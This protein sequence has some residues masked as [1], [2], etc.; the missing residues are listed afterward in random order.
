L[1]E[2]YVR[3]H[4]QIRP[5][6]GGGRLSIIVEDSGKGFDVG[7]VLAQPPSVHGLSGRGVNL[8]RQLSHSARWSEDGRCA[9]VEF[10]WEA[11]A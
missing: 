5:E 9:H 1:E 2:G 4:L 6:E 10:T 7:R 8:V 3:L 11:Q